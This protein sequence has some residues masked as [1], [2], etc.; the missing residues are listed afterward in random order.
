MLDNFNIEEE[1]SLFSLTILRPT[2]N[3]AP[4]AEFLAKPMVSASLFGVRLDLPL[5][6]GT[7]WAGWRQ[8]MLFFSC[9]LYGGVHGCKRLRLRTVLRA[10]T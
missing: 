4:I 5:L 10:V 8:V 1:R 9:F 2:V 7:T 6:I 3:S